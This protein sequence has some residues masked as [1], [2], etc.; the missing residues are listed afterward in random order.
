MSRKTEEQLINELKNKFDSL[1]K[2][3]FPKGLTEKYEK[4]YF[5]LVTF[6]ALITEFYFSSMRNR[7]IDNKNY[8][9]DVF[10]DI[11]KR[12]DSQ[13]KLLDEKIKENRSYYQAH[14]EISLLIKE[15]NELVE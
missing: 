7:E 13:L 5:D 2:I 10:P 9:S 3:R 11:I 12:I 1:K 8:A 4:I 15:I 14:N 6:E